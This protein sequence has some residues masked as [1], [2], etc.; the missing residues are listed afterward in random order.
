M[1]K[2][3]KIVVNV[4]GVTV[5]VGNFNCLNCG[6]VVHINVTFSKFKKK[7]NLKLR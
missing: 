1:Q 6:P 7:L 3:C 5:N 4:S 2:G